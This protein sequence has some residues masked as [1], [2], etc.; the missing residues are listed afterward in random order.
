MT[1]LDRHLP[2]IAAGDDDA[3]ARWLAGAEPELRD[4]LRAFA[5]VADVE[6]VLQESLLR[7]W[8]VAAR[9]APDGRPNALLRFAVRAARNLALDEARRAGRRVPSDDTTLER[10]LEALAGAGAPEGPDPLLRKL[11]ARC[12]SLLPAKPRAALDARL[13]ASGTDAALAARLGMRVNTFLQNF[14]RARRA[15]ADCLRK[16]GVEIEEARP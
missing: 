11:I 6:A 5:A 12:R 10:H 9:F 15:L 13:A 8:Q 14:G 3:F 4:G 16:G 2:E 7:T 1:D